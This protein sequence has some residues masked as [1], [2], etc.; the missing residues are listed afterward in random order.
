MFERTGMK[1]RTAAYIGLVV[2]AIVA[3][4]AV[5]VGGQ[6]PDA[7]DERVVCAVC[8]TV[9]PKR[10]MQMLPVDSIGLAPDQ[11]PIY[12]CSDSCAEVA[13]GD[14]EKYRRKAISGEGRTRR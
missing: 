2:L 14:P 8:G 11:L 9:L 1:A 3:V 12:V 13:R 6:R 5:V 10:D 4:A 7:A